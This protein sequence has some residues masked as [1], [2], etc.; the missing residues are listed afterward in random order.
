VPEI[1]WG[2][3]GIVKGEKHIPPCRRGEQVRHREAGRH[4]AFASGAGSHPADRGDLP[5]PIFSGRHGNDKTETA[6]SR[7]D[8][9]PEKTKEQRSDKH[10]KAN[11]RNMKIAALRSQ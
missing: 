6:F 2:D 4:M 10:Q 1:A 11:G 8:A 3:K 7:R 9:A 5:L